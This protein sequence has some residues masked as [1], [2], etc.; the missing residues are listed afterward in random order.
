DEGTKAYD[1]AKRE[2][3]V[4]VILR[5]LTMVEFPRESNLIWPGS[6]TKKGTGV[7]A[8]DLHRVD[9]LAEPHVQNATPRRGTFVHDFGVDRRGCDRRVGGDRGVVGDGRVRGGSQGQ[10]AARAAASGSDQPNE[11]GRRLQL[12]AARAR[13]LSSGVSDGDGHRAVHG[14]G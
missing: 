2:K 13:S 6:T 14:G 8:E 5:M 4:R 9:R 7:E 11:C 1:K 10:D 3:I 12:E